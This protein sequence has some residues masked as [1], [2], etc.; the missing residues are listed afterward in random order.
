MIRK[1]FDQIGREAKFP[2]VVAQHW[3]SDSRLWERDIYQSSLSCRHIRQQPKFAS[4]ESLA[5]G[6]QEAIREALDPVEAGCAEENTLHKEWVS[7]ET[8]AIYSGAVPRSNR[9]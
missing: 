8:T 7:S 6:E 9:P 1:E 4:S 2:A 5:A 3:P